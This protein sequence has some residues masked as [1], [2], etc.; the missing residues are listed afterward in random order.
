MKKKFLSNALCACC[1]LSFWFGSSVTSL[2]LFGEYPYPD[3]N[4]YEN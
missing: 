4:Q 2:V 1:A 3:Q